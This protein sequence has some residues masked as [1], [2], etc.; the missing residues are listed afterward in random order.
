VTP[1]IV[2][3][4]LIT[5]A[6]GVAAGAVINTVDWAACA[7]NGG[8][9]GCNESRNIAAGAWTALGMN[10]LALATNIMNDDEPR[11]S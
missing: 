11:R 3:A 9:Q 5:A 8:G 10:A 4:A 7:A 2:K 6:A 1:G